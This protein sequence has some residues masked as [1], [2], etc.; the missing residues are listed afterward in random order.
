MTTSSQARTVL[1]VD[2]NRDGADTL[3]QL[4]A[5]Y[6]HETRAVYSAQEAGRVV[7][8]GFVPDAVLLDLVLPHL[9]GFQLARELCAALPR[10]PLLVA[11]T[12]Y[13]NLG[14]RCR[15][16]GFDHYYVKPVDPTELLEVLGTHTSLTRVRVRH[17][18]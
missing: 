8:D 9:D 7:Q 15:Q 1:I 2:D 17:H 5:A 10:K 6:G 18:V 12:G 11:V 16:E 14:E 3:A 13:G 4:L